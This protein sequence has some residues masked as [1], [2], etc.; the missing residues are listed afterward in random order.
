MESLVSLSN[1]AKVLVC[2]PG[3]SLD[4]EGDQGVH[5][6]KEIQSKMNEVRMNLVPV[7][8]ADAVSWGS[9]VDSY[10]RNRPVQRAW[11]VVPAYLAAVSDFFSLTRA[12]WPGDVTLKI[13]DNIFKHLKEGTSS[14]MG[15]DVRV[16]GC[17]DDE[18]RTPVGENPGGNHLA[19]VNEWKVLLP[20]RRPLLRR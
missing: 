8:S 17:R 13:R 1:K 3:R 6:Q 20:P 16:R 12:V 4:R 14:K 11:I 15:D 2:D 5:M 18:R 10:G 7:V 19:Q 9:E